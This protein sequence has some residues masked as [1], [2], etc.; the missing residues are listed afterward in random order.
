MSKLATTLVSKMNKFSLTDK[1]TEKNIVDNPR[2]ISNPNFS[3]ITPGGCNA[4]CSFC[5]WSEQPVIEG[6]IE[7]LKNALASLPGQFEQLS[8]TGGEP[9]LSKHLGLILGAIDRKKFKKVV[10]T[11]N[12]TNL[13]SVIP[14]FTDIVDHVNI[15]RHFY[16]DDIS[17]SVFEVEDPKGLRV[18]STEELRELCGMLNQIGVDVTLSA[19]LTKHFKSKDD[20]LKMIEY[21]KNVGASFL[22]LR[23]PH[24]TLT[25]TKLEKE[26]SA[27]KVRN[28]SECPVCKTSVQ[29]I[30][31]IPVS[32]KMS[33]LEPSKVLAEEV[34][35]GVF[36]PDGR[37][38]AD[39]AGK[40][41]I[42]FGVK[43]EKVESED[44]DEDPPSKKKY[45]P[46][47]SARETVDATVNAILQRNRDRQQP[48][49]TQG[50]GSYGS[51][52]GCH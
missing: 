8:V 14:M 34:Y 15:S 36:H 26:F 27:Y 20:V 17:N 1:L 46:N 24:G 7:K 28:Y 10:L 21:T 35:E 33:V 9:T 31:G 12:G 47:R 37:M 18:P 32:W 22:F 51:T 29:L 2:T 4:R 43:K 16:E 13:K 25:Q 41:E 3:I 40:T 11:T 50:C 19:V 6:Y 5:F 38:T 44:D 49:S 45:G 23:K 39:W 42:R 30:N 48:E 52:G